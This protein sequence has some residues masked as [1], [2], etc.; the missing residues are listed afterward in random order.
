MTWKKETA[1][2]VKV[3]H[4]DSTEQL[5]EDSANVPKWTGARHFTVLMLFLGMANAYI[6]RTNMSVAIVAMVNQTAVLGEDVVNLNEC[7]AVEKPAE[8]ETVEDG[9]F[10][11]QS[12]EQSIIL[13]SFFY[14]YVVTQIPFGILAKRYGAK[15]FL[16]VGMLINSVFGVLVPL[17]AYQG[18]G[19]MITVRFIQ[20]LGEGPIVPCTHAMLSSWIPPNERSKLGAFVYA[21]AQLGTVISL[22][23]SGL[24]SRYGFGGGWPSIFYVFGAVGAIWSLAFLFTVYEDPNHHPTMHEAE[25]RYIN[26]A[27]WGKVV[28]EPSAVPW[29]SILTSMPFWAILAAHMGQ[30]YGYETLLTQLPTFMKQILHVNIKDNGWQSALPY[31]TMWIFSNVCSVTADWLIWKRGMTATFTRKLLNAIGLVGPALCMIGASYTGCSGPNTVALLSVGVGLMG[32]TMSAYRINHLDISPRYAG[33]L[34]AIT[35]CVAN[36]FALLAPLIAGQITHN[37]PT[38]AAWREVFFISAGVYFVTAAI[39]QLFA[40]GEKQ[41][42]DTPTDKTLRRKPSIVNTD[43]GLSHVVSS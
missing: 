5:T 18:E 9:P 3:R 40:S 39:Y 22:P 36:I 6:M 41:S 20:G 13:S 33:V 26:E 28:E 37:R 24:L 21:G 1:V 35:N 30:N 29:K 25:R 23:L 12:P 14:G 16:G 42:W 38:Q 34:M 4:G 10:V 31:L 15:Y 8:E 32:A 7:P 19:W 27:V 17:A 2:D 43:L 11:W